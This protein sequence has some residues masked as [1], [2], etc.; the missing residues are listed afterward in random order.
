M[1]VSGGWRWWWGAVTTTQKRRR[2][3]QAKRTGHKSKAL[4]APNPA[5]PQST[6]R[7]IPATTRRQ[8]AR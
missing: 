6:A 7:D 5:L 4:M 2:T 8:A 3:R 1:A